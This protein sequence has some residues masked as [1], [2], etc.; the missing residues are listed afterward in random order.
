MTCRRQQ[1]LN[2]ELEPGRECLIN[3]PETS[4]SRSCSGEYWKRG[5]SRGPCS[6]PAKMAL[7]RSSS[8]L[9]SP[10]LST[11]ARRRELKAAATVQHVCAS[12]VSIIHKAVNQTTGR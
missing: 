2:P 4:A 7:V 9:K 1:A 8:H 5:A 10:G 12:V 3:L 11:A 6:L